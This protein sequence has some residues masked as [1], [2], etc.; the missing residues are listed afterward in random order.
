MLAFGRVSRVVSADPT[1]AR[2]LIV[3]A[4]IQMAV[5][6]WDL[7]NSWSWEE[8]AVAPRELFMGL[9]NNLKPGSYHRYPLLHYVLFGFL[10]LP[11]SLY[12]V[13]T[14]NDWTPEAIEASFIRY[15]IMTGIAVV[16]KI[17][18]I[19]MGTVALWTLATIA[20]RTVSVTA[21]R[22]A[23]AFAV[24]NLSVGYYFRTQN[25]DGPYL[26]WTVL[27]MNSLLT[28]AER[29]GTRDYVL[30]AVFVAASIAT[31][32]QAYAAYVLVGPIYL[33]LW[34]A[35]RPTDWAAGR[36]HWRRLALAVG[37][38]ALSL[39]VLSGALLNPTGFARRFEF[40]TGPASGN[41]R[42]YTRDAA[43]FS[44][45]VHDVL[46]AQAEFWWPGPI[47]GLAW[48]GIMVAVRRP[49]G[50]GLRTR[51]WRLLPLT[52]GLSAL[53]FFTLVVGRCEHRFLLP[54]G[55]WLSFYLGV[56]ADRGLD[57]L[58]AA[59]WPRAASVALIVV[60]GIVLVRRPIALALTQWFDGRHRV[61]AFLSSLPSGST[62]ETYGRLPH[63][64]RFE[65]NG[66]YRVVHVHPTK[67]ARRRPPM[68]GV[69]MIRAPYEHVLE[70]HPD[71]IVLN[72]SIRGRY[73]QRGAL[74]RGHV[75]SNHLKQFR[76]N[77]RVIELMQAALRDELPG[78]STQL[79]AGPSI[80]SWLRRLGL[81]PVRIHA[82]TAGTF[83]ILVARVPGP[84]GDGP[85]GKPVDTR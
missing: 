29:G 51:A 61:E 81:E 83:R 42:V 84:S 65:P 8:D 59:K 1:L 47:V 68:P 85:L 6:V 35:L 34:P 54:L 19:G 60:L 23:V 44:A 9:A 69:E 39:G 76:D 56:L 48:L 73:G 20:R 49:V 36:R 30:F 27:A 62:V 24:C 50:A 2:L 70:R 28:I 12:G 43:G 10:S 15:E 71:V 3:Y 46:F 45:N 11:V 77:P 26:M 52:A 75:L 67:S 13:L 38:G 40:L 25:L 5:A 58:R 16:A 64:P 72:P 78:Y 33:L 57:A 32:D 21:G 55:F 74:P 79:V 22:W 14:A 53:F 63:Q 31:K 37:V 7:P 82:C 66:P 80:P 4:V 41:F 17:L 18:T